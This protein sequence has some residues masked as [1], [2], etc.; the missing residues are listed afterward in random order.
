MTIAEL[1]FVQVR[2]LP[3][4]A[5]W[6]VLDFFGYIHNRR[7]RAQWRDLVTAQSV[8]LATVW[9]NSEDQVWDNV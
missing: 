9:D 4:P 8:S 2:K 6:K 5:A 3:V 1:I 7:E